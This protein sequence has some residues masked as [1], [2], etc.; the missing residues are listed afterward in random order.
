MRDGT[1]KVIETVKEGEFVQGS[2]K[3]NQVL[4]TIILHHDGWLYSMNGSDYFVTESH[5]FMTKGGVWKA[6]NPEAAMKETQLTDVKE[7]R[8]GDTLITQKGEVLLQKV[9]RIWKKVDVYNFVVD[10]SHDYYADGYLVHNKLAC[11]GSYGTCPSGYDCVISTCIP[12]D[13]R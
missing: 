1:E 6:F 3:P 5:P 8:E 13:L 9:A 11:G 4:K 10:N 12:F 2:E 7:L